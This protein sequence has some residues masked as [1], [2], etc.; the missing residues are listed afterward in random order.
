[1]YAPDL[2]LEIST[3]ELLKQHFPTHCALPSS[4]SAEKQLLT[5]CIESTSGVGSAVGAAKSHQTSDHFG[6]ALDGAEGTILP[7]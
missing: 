4:V 6:P 2:D 1:M 5:A 7:R 3:F